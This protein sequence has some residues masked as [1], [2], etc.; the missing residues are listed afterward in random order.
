MVKW[1]ALPTPLANDRGGPLLYKGDDFARTDIM[2]A[3]K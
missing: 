3:Q 1:T 2:A